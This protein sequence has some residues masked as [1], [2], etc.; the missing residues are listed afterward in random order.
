M[1]N[2]TLLTALFITLMGI[3]IFTSTKALAQNTNDN[4]NPMQS[5]IQRIADK[6]GLKK[7]DVQAVFDQDRTDRQAEMEAKNLTQLDQLVKDAKITEAQKQLIINKRKEMESNRQSEMENLKDK[8]D[9][10]KKAAFETNKT[11]MDTERKALEEWA[12]QNGIDVKYLMGG[13]GGHKG[14]DGP[15]P[16]GQDGINGNLTPPSNN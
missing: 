12:A 8:T 1:K 6:F 4:P 15:G 16:N 10:E 9:E 11:K 5:L 3:G 13:F 2:K 14:P 7:D